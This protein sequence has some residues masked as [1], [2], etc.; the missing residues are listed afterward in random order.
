MKVAKGAS[1]GRE[2][3]LI[4]PPLT[5]RGNSCNKILNCLRRENQTWCKPP[6][7][8]VALWFSKKRGDG[9][10]RRDWGG[11]KQQ[12]VGPQSKGGFFYSGLAEVRKIVNFAIVGKSW[13]VW[14]LWMTE[15]NRHLFLLLWFTSPVSWALNK[16]LQ[17]LKSV[18][19]LGM[20]VC[21]FCNWLVNTT[22]HQLPNRLWLAPTYSPSGERTGSA[23]EGCSFI[24]PSDKL[25]SS[26]W[27]FLIHLVNHRLPPVRQKIFSLGCCES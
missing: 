21:Y 7:T 17:L 24:K 23:E 25:K 18:K 10:Q 5:T 2:M 11:K 1:Y 12:S 4:S 26:T 14:N 27:C 15:Q 13:F 6:A 16:D 20:E 9:V 22:C 8:P 3:L 19:N